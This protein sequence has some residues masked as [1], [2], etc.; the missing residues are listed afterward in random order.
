MACS[1]RMRWEECR[2]RVASWAAMTLGGR[3]VWRL[4]GRP[5]HA[6]FGGVHQR[7]RVVPE[8]GHHVGEG[9]EPDAVAHQAAALSQQ[10]PDLG[11]A[12]ADRRTVDTEPGDDDVV[13]Q[14][15]A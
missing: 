13:G 8:V 3:E 9:P 14:P 10:R 7:L 4:R 15:V 12:A 1:T 6:D 11:D 2:L 5:T